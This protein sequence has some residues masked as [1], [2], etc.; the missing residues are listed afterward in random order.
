MPHSA[1]RASGEKGRTILKIAVGLALVGLLAGGIARIF[2][3]RFESGDAY[4]PYSSLR[5][6]PVGTA[7]LHDA[8]GREPA[9]DV[10]RNRSPLDALRPPVPSAVLFLGIAHDEIAGR[11]L[12]KEAYRLAAYGH[13]V[14]L[15]AR[16]VRETFALKRMPG[17]AVPTPDPTP[18][19]AATPAD[20]AAEEA[21]EETKAV[22]PLVFG[23]LPEREAEAEERVATIEAPGVAPSMPWGSL[24]YIKQAPEGWETR[25]TVDGK[26]VVL[27]RRHGR[28]S[29]VLIADAFPFSNEA[30]LEARRTDFLNWVLAGH[31]SVVF[32]ETH[33]G[34]H[35]SQTVMGLARKHRLGGLFAV[36][37]IAGLLFVWRNA[38]PFPPRRA[39]ADATADVSGMDSGAGPAQPAPAQR[40]PGQAS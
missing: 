10:A 19:P 12:Q 5:L 39:G 31:R 35:R 6:D 4:P 1:T 16:P 26:P 11:R 7:V 22:K 15:A 29:L 13:R 37:A 40:P 28:G 8:L 36:A 27:E 21:T 23:F 30:M 17:R 32:E 18:S 14:V 25:G 9:A 20:R 33:H 2:V 34:I 3:K 38:S 24:L